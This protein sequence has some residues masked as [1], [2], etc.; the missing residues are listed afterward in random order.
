[1]DEAIAQ[2][3]LN[4][5]SGSA[6]EAA[7]EAA[8]QLRN[9]RQ[10]QR[11]AIELQVEQARYEAQLAARRYDA[12]DPENRLVAAELEC[13]W[14]AALEKARELGGKLQQFDAEIGSVPMPDKEVLMSLAQDLPAVWNASSSDMRLKQRIVRILIHEIVVD[15]N[16]K[17]HETVLLIHWAGGRHSELRVKKN[18]TGHHSRCTG[19]EAIEVM[20]Q[21][22]VGHTDEQIAATFF[23]CQVFAPGRKPRFAATYKG[24]AIP[25][26]SFSRGRPCACDGKAYFPT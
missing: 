21:M 8:D 18:R 11:R 2:E 23:S 3:V 13:R 6:V 17:D 20:R 15:V 19:L 7:L 14:N 10:Q 24:P 25:A 26:R 22:A 1:V 4:A 16:E 12:V 9:H 5:I